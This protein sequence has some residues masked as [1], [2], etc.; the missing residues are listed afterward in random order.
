MHRRDGKLIVSATDLVGFLECG[1]LT[2]LE[3]QA[4]AGLIHKPSQREDPEVLLLQRR[5]HEHEARYIDVLR[6]RGLEVVTGDDD[7]D[8]SYD[9][10]A[11]RTVELMHDGVD[12]I[13]QATVFDGRWLGFPDFLMRKEGRPSSATRLYRFGPGIYRADSEPAGKPDEHTDGASGIH[14]ADSGPGRQPAMA[15]EDAGAARAGQTGTRLGHDWHY[16][17][18][19]TKLAH[20]AKAT[21][22]IQIAS[23]V[24]QIE[25]IQGVR[26]E[27]VY[28]VTGGAEAEEHAFRTAEMM[29]YY[30]R[31]KE[32]FEQTLA[33]ELDPKLT[34]PDPVAH[35]SVC[36][37]YG[38]YCWRTWREDD[39]LPL[40]AGISRAQRTALTTHN[41]STR[42]ALSELN[43]AFD[44]GLKKSQDESM[45]KVRE[46]A[47][48]QRQSIQEGKTLYEILDPERDAEGSLVPDRGLSVL[49]PPNEGDLFFDIEGDPFAFWEGLEYLFGVW[50]T[51][52]SESIWEQD[53]Y[54]GIWA[55][56]NEE[57]QF[58]RAAEKRAFE[59]VMDL[60]KQRL[61]QFPDMHIYHYGAYEP[62]HLKML[63][64]RH[65][66]RE[67]ALDELLRKRVFVDLYRAVRQGLRVGAE[68]YSIKKLEDLYAYKRE[69]DLRDA[70]SS[71]VEFE[72]L[73]EDGDASGETKERIRLYNRDDCVST[74]KLRD[75]LE[76]RRLE[77]ARQFS[78]E[79]PRPSGEIDAP[80][81]DFT[82]RQQEV[83]DLEER[84]TAGIADDPAEQSDADKATWL[85]RHLVD[86]HRRENKSMWW[87][88]YELMGMSEDELVDEAE[89]IG[90]L[91]FVGI[92]ED[93][94]TRQSDDYR[95]R[96]PTQEHKIGIDT[97]VHDPEI[98]EG[99][100][101]TGSV[102]GLDDVAGTV[103]IRRKKGWADHHPEAIVPLKFIGAK[104][105]QQALM[106]L[107][108]WIAD[109]GIAADARSEYQAGRELLLRL[110]PRAGQASGSSLI[111]TSETGSDA[112]LRLAPLLDCTTLPIQGPPGSGKTYTGARMILELV[113]AGKKLGIAANSHKVI[114]NLLDAVGEAAA[115]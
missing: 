36:K 65:A 106:R 70:N 95:Y 107:G 20:T 10:R 22:L 108:N 66:T 7:W 52:Q 35:C 14:R 26:P 57:K 105:Q 41:V 89:P 17:V 82:A 79:L 71:I 111:R 75:W 88:F 21:A 77:A 115:R 12:V 113:G 25:R 63:V 2:N 78:F 98:T 86:W 55:Y 54:T 59:Q 84:L 5:G 3:L 1:H 51:P 112:A 18:A 8:H 100:T 44:L 99:D 90:Q 97:E 13:Y 103:D 16:E 45:W 4:D 47:R 74:E 43:R 9:Q 104:A 73:L 76:L 15:G 40:V 68:S 109:N 62:S 92:V 38:D 110:P 114:A 80:N 53:A 48:L 42:A 23:Y 58:T 49:P 37:W 28:V 24:E 50:E 34:Y 32:R 11:A 85:I 61:A 101:R 30:R 6:S 81:E 102:V 83:R 27:R 19:D 39:A 67:E 91:E 56:D 94:G 46:Q 96:F 60:F 72:F 29:A 64:G 33:A 31:A 93:G 87:R 69:V